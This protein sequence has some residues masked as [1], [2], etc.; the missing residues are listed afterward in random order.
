M[1]LSLL[2]G[3]CGCGFCTDQVPRSSPVTSRETQKKVLVGTLVGFLGLALAVA[4]VSPDGRVLS[5]N[6][7]RQSVTHRVVMSG[8][9][10]PDAKSNTS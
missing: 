8:K 10:T 7:A 4:L 6:G 9:R 2:L 5:I 3:L 1:V